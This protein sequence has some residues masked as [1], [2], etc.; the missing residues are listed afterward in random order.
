MLLCIGAHEYGPTGE[1]AGGGHGNVL[2]GGGC[3]VVFSVG[4]GWSP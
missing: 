2:V 4:P 3:V 1:V